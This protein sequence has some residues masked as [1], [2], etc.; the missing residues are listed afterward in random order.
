M[1][2]RPRFD[3]KRPLVAAREFIFA[4]KTYQ[5][6]DPFNP[7]GVAQRARARQYEARA[8]NHGEGEEA[9]ASADPIQMTGPKGGRYTITAPWL[10]EPEVVRGKVNAEKRLAELHEAGEPASYGGYTLTEGENGWWKITKDGVEGADGAEAPV[11]NVQGED[12]ARQAVAQL[13]AGEAPADTAL[14]EEW[15]PKP[16]DAG[17]GG[18][19]QGQTGVDPEGNQAPEDTTVTQ[20]NKDKQTADTTANEPGSNEPNGAEVIN[21]QENAGTAAE[22]SG[23]DGEG[24][25]GSTGTVGP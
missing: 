13:R 7:E 22:E 15:T 19:Q 11:L 18:E 23:D 20:E 3:P 24:G 16:A 9:A 4:G 8:V 12:N 21:D 1:A 6:G 14:P 2:A 10:D 25:D 17:E 5:P